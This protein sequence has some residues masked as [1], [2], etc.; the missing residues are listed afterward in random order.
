MYT[1]IG[2][3]GTHMNH[4]QQGV[5]AAVL[6]IVFLL[7]SS[8]PSWA[9]ASYN[10][11]SAPAEAQPD[12]RQQLALQVQKPGRMWPT[13]PIELA[14]AHYEMAVKQP[15]TRRTRAGTLSK[16]RRA[17]S[18]PIP[19]LVHNMQKRSSQTWKPILGCHRTLARPQP[20]PTLSNN[21]HPPMRPQT[22]RLPKPN[23]QR[24]LPTRPPPRNQVR[25]RRPTRRAK[26]LNIAA[27]QPTQRT[28]QQIRRRRITRW[29]SHW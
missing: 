9:Q 3:S 6:C 26:L 19:T 14:R 18:R 29:K 1:E 13:R 12:H 10:D 23:S 27:Q 7:I 4:S 25:R 16:P 5:C 20:R 22:P 17:V 8:S 15:G 11:A 28:P 24:P 21:Q 2:Y